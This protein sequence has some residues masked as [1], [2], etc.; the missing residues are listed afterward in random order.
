[1]LKS[2]SMGLLVSYERNF[3]MFRKTVKPHELAFVRIQRFDTSIP[4]TG[5]FVT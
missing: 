1:M 2:F 5:D 4:I 3:L